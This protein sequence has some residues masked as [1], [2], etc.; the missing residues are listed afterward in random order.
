MSISAIIF[1]LT[2]LGGVTVNKKKILITAAIVFLIAAGAIFLMIRMQGVK[3]SAQKQEEIGVD[4]PEETGTEIPEEKGIKPPEMTGIEIPEEL[5]LAL[6]N[7][8]GE[9]EVSDSYRVAVDPDDLSVTA[10]LDEEWNHF[11]LL[12]TDA[13]SGK[14]NEGRSDSMVI[15]SINSKTKDL[16]ITSLVRDILTDIPGM[17]SQQRIN[18]ANAFGGPLLAVKTVNE[19][20]GLNISRYISVS[21][22]S[23]ADIVDALGGVELTLSKSEA[24]LAKAK[25]S[26]QP[27]ILTGIQA[28]EYSRIRKLDNNFGR[29]ERQRKVLMAILDKA[30]T[31]G[32]NE[33]LALLPEMLKYVSTNLTTS[34]ILGLMP[35]VLGN[36]DGIEMLSLPLENDFHYGKSN[37]NASVVII[38]LEKTRAAFHDFIAGKPAAQE[39]TEEEK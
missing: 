33:L 34:E 27:Q 6:E 23:F 21:F 31:L 25:I 12:G 9:V 35:V 11:L 3:L 38:D 4:Y 28:L 32:Q 19:L 1:G 36:T 16:K 14:L 7:D 13:H 30:M 39:Q 2:I 20:L 18:T 10:G 15:A 29:N 37:G 22:S 5:L 8:E 26:N 24:N 17:K